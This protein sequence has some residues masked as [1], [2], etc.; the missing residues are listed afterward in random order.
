MSSPENQLRR[1]SWQFDFCFGFT[2]VDAVLGAAA[3]AVFG[4]LLPASGS[5]GYATI[6]VEDLDV[7]SALDMHAGEERGTAHSAARVEAEARSVELAAQSSV[8]GGP[9]AGAS[10]RLPSPHSRAP[11]AGQRKSSDAERAGSAFSV[12]TPGSEGAR[13]HST[14]Q[15]LDDADFVVL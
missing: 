3:A 12:V 10:I 5:V 15:T 4:R 6:R 9:E 7:P 1:L 2:L 13:G 11:S 14:P 8:R